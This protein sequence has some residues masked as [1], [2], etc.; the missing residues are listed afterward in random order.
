MAMARDRL[1]NG[2]AK[3]QETNIVVDRMQTELNELQPV[4]A[5]KT[6]DTQRLLVQVGAGLPFAAG[7]LEMFTA[8]A[9]HRGAMLHSRAVHHCNQGQLH[10]CN[11]ALKDC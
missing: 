1:L 10:H 8:Q 11:G 5:E 9:C 2:L 3:L 6:K 7:I 4:L